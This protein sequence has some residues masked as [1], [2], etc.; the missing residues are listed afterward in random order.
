MNPA[1][2]SFGTLVRVE[3][4]N[5]VFRDCWFAFAMSDPAAYSGTPDVG[6]IT[7]TGGTVILREPSIDRATG[8]AETVPLLEIRA[9][10]VDVSGAQR[11]TLGGSWSGR[12]RVKVTGGTVLASDYSVTL[13]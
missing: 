8:V 9:G 12:P 10:E 1:T 2:P 11:G 5:V 4:G 7:Q 6:Y 13:I 3:G